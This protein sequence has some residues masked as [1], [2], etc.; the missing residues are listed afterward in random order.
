M[1]ARQAHNLKVGG[2]IPSSA[3]K[4]KTARQPML[5]S[6]FLVLYSSEDTFQEAI[7]ES[8][9]TCPLPS[10]SPKPTLITLLLVFAQETQ[11]TLKTLSTNN[12]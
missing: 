6:L 9:I 3:T 8:T 2:S 7:M 5:S 1:V 12:H 10:S 4:E 11:D